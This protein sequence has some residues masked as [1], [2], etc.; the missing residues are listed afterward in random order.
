MTVAGL[1]AAI[2]L[3]A[4]V[5]FVHELGHFLAAKWCDVE[6]RVFSM[7]FGPTLFSRTVGETDYRLAAI[8]LGGYVR[9]AGQDDDELGEEAPED[10]ERGFTAK[11]VPQ[12]GLIIAAGPAVNF[13]F[14]ILVFTAVAYIYG[15]PMPSDVPTVG[16]LH[17][18][19]PAEEGGLL[20]GDTITSVDGE[21]VRDWSHLADVVIGSEGHELTFEVEG[22]G[23]GAARTVGVTPRLADR[24]DEFGEVIG[25]DYMIGVDRMLIPH[26]VGLGTAIS[27]GTSQT[28]YFSGVVLKTLL[29]LVQGRVSSK[30]VGG[31]ILIAQVASRKAR[32]GMEPFLFFM[33]LISV[34]L[35]LINVLPIPV[36]DG[37][38]LAFLGFEA[39]RGKPLSLRVRE[40]ALQVGIVFIGA[41]MIFVVFNDLRR[42]ITG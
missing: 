22:E 42:I 40:G 12:R 26:P 11:S 18:G 21:R 28:V 29:R 34:N 7:G 2:L 20:T 24:R 8:P 19:S 37:G 15:I 3:L 25:T 4:I 17:P 39:L 35:G 16:A 6:V 33:A 30:D 5:I 1:L 27:A 23:G 31:P 10:P 14:A 13:I 32:S 9:M 36:L 41:V 38:H